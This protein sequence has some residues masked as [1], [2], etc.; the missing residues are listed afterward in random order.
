VS[1]DIHAQL[2]ERL[3]RQPFAPFAIETT[4]GRSIVVRERGQAVL[5]ALAISIVEAAFSVTVI[6]LPQV[7]AI[8]ALSE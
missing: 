5:N 4:D 6:G 3:G 8:T 1:A 2:A 7:R